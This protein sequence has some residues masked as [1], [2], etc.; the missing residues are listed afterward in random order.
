VEGED[1]WPGWAARA[2]KGGVGFFVGAGPRS[3]GPAAA[4][5]P[6]VPVGN[7]LDLVHPAAFFEN[8]IHET[9]ILLAVRRI[10]SP[11]LYFMHGLRTVSK[12]RDSSRFWIQ[13]SDHACIHDLL[14]FSESE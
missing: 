5:L 8:S 7:F 2:R 13:F 1:I 9:E 10:R 3:A 12:T 4:L 6:G 11:V 14:I